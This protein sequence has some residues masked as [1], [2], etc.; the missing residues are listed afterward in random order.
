[1]F[2]KVAFLC[3]GAGLHFIVFCVNRGMRCVEQKWDN[4]LSVHTNNIAALLCEMFREKLLS[5]VS[6]SDVNLLTAYVGEVVHI[7]LFF[8]QFALSGPAYFLVQQA[9]IGGSRVQQVKP[10][11]LLSHL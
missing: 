11:S 2:S 8:S 10:E 3:T 4:R 9:V 1:M 6:E 7:R 5:Q